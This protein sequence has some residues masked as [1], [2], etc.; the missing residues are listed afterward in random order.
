MR[1]N[2]ADCAEAKTLRSLCSSSRPRIPA[3][4][5]P[6]TS[7]Q[8]SFASVSSGAIWRSRR[9]RPRPLTIRTQSRQKKPSSTIAV[10]RCVA[11]RNVMKNLSFWWMSHPS[12]FGRM[13]LW[14]RLE[15]GNSSLT[16]CSRPRTIACP[17]EMGNE[18]VLGGRLRPAWARGAEPGEDE[19]CR[20][21]EERG[22]PVLHMVMGRPRLV[23]REEARQRLR[24]LD[25]VDDR[26]RD[27]DDARP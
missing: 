4:I 14:P 26:D 6:T 3:G 12:S 17:Y 16:P 21:Q 25:P 15:I 5:V 8:P 13:T 24:R 23:A 10:A 19:A 9:E 20:A 27:Q 11:T 1:K 2:A 7:S 22:D 18:A